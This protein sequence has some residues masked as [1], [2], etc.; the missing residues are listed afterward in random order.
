MSRLSPIAA[1]ENTRIGIITADKVKLD[2]VSGITDEGDQQNERD[3]DPVLPDREQRHVG[4]VVGLV[5]AGL[6]VEHFFQIR[7]MM[8]SPNSPCGRNSRKTS[9]IA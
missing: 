7:S 1:S 3:A 2:M 4:G 6:A 9:A 5:L 8:R